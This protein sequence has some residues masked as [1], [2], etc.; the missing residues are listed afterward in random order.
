MLLFTYCDSEKKWSLL[1][2]D[3]PI[4]D[5]PYVNQMDSVRVDDVTEKM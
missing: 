3:Q 2:R 1:R 5:F 4:T